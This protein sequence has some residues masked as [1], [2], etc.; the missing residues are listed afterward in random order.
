[1]IL[2][3]TYQPIPFEPE[4]DAALKARFPAAIER[5]I[6]AVEQLRAFAGNSPLLTD[7]KHFF[8]FEIGVRMIATREETPAGN[9]FHLSFGIPPG[10]KTTVFSDDALK[11]FARQTSLELLGQEEPFNTLRTPMA[12]QFYFPAGEIK[13][14]PRR[15]PLAK[16]QLDAQT[17]C[18]CANCGNAAHALILTGRCHPGKPTKASYARG[19]G[20]LRIECAVCSTLILEIQVAAS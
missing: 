15:V 3:G 7:R 2:S 20:V 14:A 17:G 18:G 6:T 11:D 10:V 16:P 9:F 1:M 4:P 13:P 19:S 8:D 5:L 12:L